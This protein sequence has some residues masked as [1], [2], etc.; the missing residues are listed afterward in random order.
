MKNE[1]EFGVSQQ[2]ITE[3][4]FLLEKTVSEKNLL[5]RTQD[6]TSRINCDSL[7]KKLYPGSFSEIHGYLSDGEELNHSMPLIPAPGPPE[8]QPSP[9][10]G[11]QTSLPCLHIVEE[12]L[13]R[14]KNNNSSD[15]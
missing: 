6:E 12:T 8:G 10:K 9:T 11:S 7:G 13:P 4:E 2:N 3:T 15:C 1:S 5:N 14:E